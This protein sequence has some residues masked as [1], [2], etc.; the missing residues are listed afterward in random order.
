MAR[1]RV[2]RGPH[3]LADLAQ[4]FW[5]AVQRMG[6][7]SGDEPD[8]DHDD[9]AGSGVPRRPAPTSGFAGAEA[10]P[11]DYA[12]SADQVMSNLGGVSGAETRGG[13]LAPPRVA[14]PR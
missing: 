3:E 9:E 5:F 2:P 4:E 11:D 6:Q 12:E 7:S 13:G 8:R 10:V 14:K 1:K